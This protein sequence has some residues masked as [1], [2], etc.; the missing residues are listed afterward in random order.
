[1]LHE[2]FILIHFE[3]DQNLLSL[4]LNYHQVEYYLVLDHDEPYLKLI[5][6]KFTLVVNIS[7]CIEKLPE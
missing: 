4:N 5:I 3:L 7:H 6:Y 2:S 1:M